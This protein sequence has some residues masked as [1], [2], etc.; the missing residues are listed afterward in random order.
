MKKVLNKYSVWRNGSCWLNDIADYNGAMV[1]VNNILSG[2]NYTEDEVINTITGTYTGDPDNELKL[3]R[4]MRGY[5]FR[6]NKFGVIIKVTQTNEVIELEER[7]DII[8]NKLMEPTR[9]FNGTS[10]RLN[11]IEPKSKFKIEDFHD[12]D[13]WFALSVWRNKGFSTLGKQKQKR[14]VDDGSAIFDKL[15]NMVDQ[16]EYKP[17]MNAADYIR[18]LI[19]DGVASNQIRKQMSRHFSNKGELRMLIGQLKAEA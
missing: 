11:T 6:T 14:G 19:R 10:L 3:L 16:G 4:Y 5:W 7:M 2:L 9:S 18:K 15:S 12:P 13:T 8:D 1:V 17:K